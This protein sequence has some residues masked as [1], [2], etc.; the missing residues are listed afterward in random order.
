MI[1]GRMLF[2]TP[3]QDPYNVY[4]IIAFTLLSFLLSFIIPLSYSVLGII[5]LGRVR[6]PPASVMVRNQ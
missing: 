5:S 3:K 2:E 1:K 6:P 4:G